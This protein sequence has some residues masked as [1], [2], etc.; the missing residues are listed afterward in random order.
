LVKKHPEL[1]ER[2]EKVCAALEDSSKLKPY[3]VIKGSLEK[4]S[5]AK[6]ALA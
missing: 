6:E 5:A 2:L 4:I 3:I 1:L